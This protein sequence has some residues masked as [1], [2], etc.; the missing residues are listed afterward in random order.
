VIW[1]LAELPKN[2]QVING[3]NVK[4]YV[5]LTNSHNGSIAIDFRLTT[6]RVVCQNTLALALRD[7]DKKTFFKHAHQGNYSHLKIQVEA[8]FEDTLKAVD[9][10]EN[11]FK[12]MMDRKFDDDLIKEYIENLF[13]M[14]NKPF[15]EKI[16]RIVM[17]RYLSKVK[18]MEE[19]RTKIAHLRL[20]GKGADLPGVKESLWGTF[21]AVLEY[22]DHS[23]L[24]GNIGLSSNLLGSGAAFKRKAFDVAQGYLS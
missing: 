24:G 21:N 4:P 9:D 22:V 6:V 10:L 15:G 18:K 5:L 8:F 19:S 1:V 14:P 13:P 7:T 23:G 16:S 20:Y 11:Q 2:I 17:N 3:D 12:A